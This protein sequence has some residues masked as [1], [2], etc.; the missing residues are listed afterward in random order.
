[1]L[2]CCYSTDAGTSPGLG[3]VTRSDL[4]PD[5]ADRF[6]GYLSRV[7][8]LVGKTA[9]V[10]VYPVISPSLPVQ[11]EKVQGKYIKT[12][13]KRTNTKLCLFVSTGS[14]YCIPIFNKTGDV[15]QLSIASRCHWLG[16]PGVF[17]R[18]VYCAVLHRS[19]CCS[20]AWRLRSPTHD[21][22]SGSTSS[23]HQCVS[24]GHVSPPPS[25]SLFSGILQPGAGTRRMRSAA[26][27][28]A[29]R[30]AAL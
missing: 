16:K 14:N 20:V 23:R 7:K 6:T 28:P 2:F 3:G 19:R 12:S 11:Q 8:R 1:M 22:R 4:S 18:A 5:L 24:D 13:Y 15:L 25:S 9:E 30:L 29:E 27:A 17:H 10:P 26:T 21:G